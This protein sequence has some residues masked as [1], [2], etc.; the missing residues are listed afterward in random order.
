MANDGREDEWFKR[1]AAVSPED[2]RASSRLK[3]RIYSALM[4]P[5]ERKEP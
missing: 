4:Q 3:S 2:T 1:L 5:K